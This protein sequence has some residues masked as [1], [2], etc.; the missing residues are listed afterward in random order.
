MLT[1][2]CNAQIKIS[3]GRVMHALQSGFLIQQTALLTDNAWL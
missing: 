3:D 2:I 1:L